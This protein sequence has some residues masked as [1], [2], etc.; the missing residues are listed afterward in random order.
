MDLNLSFD[1]FGFSSE[2]VYKIK[3]ILKN[4]NIFK[5]KMD[6]LFGKQLSGS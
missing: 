6:N 3:S 2:K 5:Q 1:N 4:K